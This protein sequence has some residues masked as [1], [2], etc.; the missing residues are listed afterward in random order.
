MN[1]TNS[2]FLPSTLS[3]KF[4]FSFSLRVKPHFSLS[5][6]QISLVVQAIH[7]TV[8]V[9][10]FEMSQ[11]ANLCAQFAFLNFLSI[12]AEDRDLF[13]ESQLNIKDLFNFFP[14]CLYK[15]NSLFVIKLFD[16]C[17]KKSQNFL[18]VV[19]FTC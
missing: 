11:F 9:S 1:S 17:L 16:F 7:Q 6:A 5:S 8:F 18:F 14:L 4:Q 2:N 10:I 3:I 15:S 19:M 13:K 12:K